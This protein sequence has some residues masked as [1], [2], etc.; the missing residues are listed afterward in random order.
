MSGSQ[1][2]HVK[3]DTKSAKWDNNTIV[4]MIKW[5]PELKGGEKLPPVILERLTF[6]TSPPPPVG[7][8]P[9][10]LVNLYETNPKVLEMLL[11]WSDLIIFDYLTHHNDRAIGPPS[12]AMRDKQPLMLHKAREK[13]LR[14]LAFRF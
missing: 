13:T 1:W 2:T 7:S 8:D 4:A 10:E 5:I 6:S 3:E 11:Q 9:H 12:L 14:N